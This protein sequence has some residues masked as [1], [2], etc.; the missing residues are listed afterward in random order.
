VPETRGI[1][2]EL[3]IFHLHHKEKLPAAALSLLQ[4][5]LERADG[6]V[7]D[8]NSGADLQPIVWFKLFRSQFE[9]TLRDIEA[10]MIALAERAFQH[11]Q[12]LIVADSAVRERWQDAFAQTRSEESCE[13]LGGA[14]LLH[15]GIFG[16][17][18]RGSGDAPGSGEVTDLVFQEP[19]RDVDGISRIADGLVLTEWKC[20]TAKNAEEKTE[21][22]ISQA[23]LYKLGVLGGAELRRKRYI[24]VVSE[25][26]LPPP[27]QRELGKATYR[28]ISI[29]VAPEPASVSARKRS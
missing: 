22:A 10:P 1:T 15:H 12:R 29:R 24:V 19:V 11:L 21:E 25:N 17:K 3:A 13:K 8:A 2:C 18:V 26:F 16:F 4:G 7:P 5:F 23:E 27:F 9:Y 14:H 20:V 28:R 6:I